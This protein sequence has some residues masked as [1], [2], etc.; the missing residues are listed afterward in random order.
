[1]VGEGGKKRE[2]P[3]WEEDAKVLVASYTKNTKKKGVEM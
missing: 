2:Y 3:S 1:M